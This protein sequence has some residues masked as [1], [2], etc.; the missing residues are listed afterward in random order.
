[1]VGGAASCCKGLLETQGQHHGVHL[2]P[3]SSRSA[4]AGR[5]LAA[6]FGA[7]AAVG[8]LEVGR[9]LDRQGCEGMLELAPPRSV[10]VRLGMQC[11][12]LDRFL[13]F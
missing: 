12:C 3:V 7:V 2:L 4:V 13:T 6:L 5:Y 8:P 10:E 9:A 11:T 1:M